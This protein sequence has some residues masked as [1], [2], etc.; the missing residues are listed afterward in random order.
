TKCAII[1]V[2][3]GCLYLGAFFTLR[4]RTHVTVLDGPIP[5]WLSRWKGASFSWFSEDQ[6]TNTAC[7]Y[8]FWPIELATGTPVEDI[9]LEDAVATRGLIYV[10]KLDILIRLDAMWQ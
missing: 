5:S 10:R 2:M 9:S 6:R 4:R 7:F 8:I 1:L 3:V